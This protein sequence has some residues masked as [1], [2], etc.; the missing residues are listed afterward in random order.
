MATNELKSRIKH[1]YKTESEWSSSNPV[2]LKG[3]VAYSSDKANKHKVGDGTS[4]WSQ[5][6]YVLPS[7]S[8]IGLG[9]V[10][11]KSS[12]TIRGELTKA[13]VTTA[14]GYTPPT[15]NTTY[16][17]ATS[18]ALGLVKSGT[19]ITVDSSGNVSVNDD[20]HNHVISNVDGLQSALDGKSATS[21]THSYLP[22]S[23][24]TLTDPNNIK[25]QTPSNTTISS[26]A[27]SVLQ[28]PIPK[29][30]WHDVFAF[31]NYSPTYYTSTDGT[32]WNSSTLDL[33]LFAQKENQTIPVLTSSIVGARWV[34]NGVSYNSATYIVIG[35]TYTSPVSSTTITIDASTNNTSWTTL[36]SSTHSYNGQPAWFYMPSIGNYSYLRIT[37]TKSS[38]DTGKCNISCIKCLTSR[39]GDQ[40][41]GSELE[42]PYTWDENKNIT[43]PQKLVVN[44]GITGALSGNADTATK[45]A[46]ARTIALTGS[47]T[48]SGSFD[49][50]GNL[51]IATTT[52]HT[53]NYAGSSSAGG[54]ANSVA[55]ALTISLNGT[56]QGAYNGSAAKSINITPSAIGAAASS[57][58]NHVPTTQTAN[59][60]IFLRNDNTWQT[61]T[62]ANIGAAASSHTH[63]SYVNQNAFS[64]I[65]VGSTTV[66]ADSAT[67][68]LTIVAGSNIT[69]TPDATNDKIT[70]ASKDTVYTHP[71]TTGNKH[72]PSGGSSGQILRWSAD[73]TAAWGAD[74]NTTY[75]AGT[76]ISLS[77]TT[78][79][80]SGVRSIA[81]GETNGTISVNTNGTSAEVAVKGLGSAAYTDSSAYAASG[82]THDEYV[83][84]INSVASSGLEICSYDKEK[85]FDVGSIYVQYASGTQSGVVNTSSQTFAGGKTFSNVAYFKS[86][87]LTGERTS[88]NDGK[89]GCYVAGSGYIQIQNTGTPALYFFK[90]T[91]TSSNN[92]IYSD[93][94]KLGFKSK[95][96]IA[97]NNGMSLDGG[98]L[99]CN[100]NITVGAN[101]V[102]DSTTRAAKVINGNNNV[103]ISTSTSAGLYHHSDNG[104]SAKWLIYIN[105][106]GTVT[107]NTSDRRWKVDKGILDSQEAKTILKS[108]DIINFIYKDD[109]G[110]NN[111]EQPGI[112]AQDLRDVLINNNYPNRGYLTLS[113]FKTEEECCEPSYDMSLPEEDNRY[114]V[115][116]SKFIPVLWKGWQ[117]HDTQIDNNT[118]EIAQLKETINVLLQKIEQLENSNAS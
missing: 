60:A 70:I 2:L 46:I 65:T 104:A 52:N 111:L 85:T 64:N 92:Y 105:T 57:H 80:N 22:L 16:G 81:T 63:S 114:D 34:F 110:K 68:T 109:V 115:D 55:N 89:A 49:G 28:S 94:D 31:G 10:E 98:G 37:L 33:R 24:G 67:D 29:Y 6:A 66:A 62:P 100:G 26:S 83:T 7:K 14:L 99:T 112:Y 4:T 13:N 73:G 38:S 41:K 118:N 97:V 56:S 77:G 18:S 15:T 91:E 44:G 84:S 82:H 61:V 39:W 69:L 21:H 76:G 43:M 40:G 102:N 107:A 35:F 108:I 9:N 19:D 103:S 106:S 23:G 53:H 17:A 45:L 42:Y 32:S 36:H 113:N 48:G 116:Y 25:F 71:T 54:A 86:G 75:S 51:S 3:E 88:Y 27:S 95:G 58:G 74:N 5:L 30:L 87:L 101:I 11:N 90:G 47:V 59:N 50:S 79:S 117:G 93:G 12:A 1:A 96:T 20:S 8:D 78:F 72:I